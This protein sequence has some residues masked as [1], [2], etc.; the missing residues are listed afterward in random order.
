MEGKGITSNSMCQCP[1]YPF[2][3]VLYPVSSYTDPRTI[4]PLLPCRCA[5]SALLR[6]DRALDKEAPVGREETGILQ[7]LAV[8]EVVD[9]SAAYTCKCL[10]IE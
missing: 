8:Q 10:F 5:L 4:I 6:D 2:D 7:L 3:H 1:L 9:D